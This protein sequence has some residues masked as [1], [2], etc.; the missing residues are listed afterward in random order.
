M[1]GY[2]KLAI[3]RMSTEAGIPHHNTQ[4][5]LE[6]VNILLNKLVKLSMEEEEEEEEE[7]SLVTKST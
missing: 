6:K 2:C 1:T 4:W 5:L 3:S 7:K